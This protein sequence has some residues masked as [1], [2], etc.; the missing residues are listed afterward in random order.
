METCKKVQSK[1][2][3]FHFNIILLLTS[4]HIIMPL[5]YTH[6]VSSVWDFQVK[7]LYAFLIISILASCHDPN[8]TVQVTAVHLT[9][10]LFP[11]LFQ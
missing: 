6:M 8:E 4:K 1:S 5:V 3:K 11:S 9:R 7:Y 2:R 10:W